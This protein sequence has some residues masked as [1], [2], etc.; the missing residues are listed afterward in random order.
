MAESCISVQDIVVNP[1]DLEGT[2]IQLRYVKFQN[3]TN[4]Q[5]FVKDN[6]SGD[7]KTVIDYLSFV[8]API[9]T[10]QMSDFKRIAGKKGE[11]H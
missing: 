6:Q 5:L 10:T 8:G 11:A 7:E 1:K 4:I 9:I 3:V 2:P